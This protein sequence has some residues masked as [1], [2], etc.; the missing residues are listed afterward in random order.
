MS[1]Q[2]TTGALTGTTLGY[3][4]RISLALITILMNLFAQ[5]FNFE[6]WKWLALKH[7]GDLSI[8]VGVIKASSLHTSK[9]QYININRDNL[10]KILMYLNGR[11]DETF[12]CF[13][14]NFWG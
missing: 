13:V 3:S 11:K 6:L 1:P 10:L 8:E 12:E 14:N 5:S 7:I 4:M 2:T 9:L